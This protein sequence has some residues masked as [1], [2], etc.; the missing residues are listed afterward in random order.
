MVVMPEDAGV[1]EC[2]ESVN[3]GHHT[4][5]AHLRQHS[6][7]VLHAS[8]SVE[9]PSIY[10][11]ERGASSNGMQLSHCQPR[12]HLKSILD[13]KE[14]G[15]AGQAGGNVYDIPGPFSHATSSMGMQVKLITAH[16]STTASAF[17]ILANNRV[18]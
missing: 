11:L 6:K 13:A 10:G 7:P 17:V 16:T 3:C 15:H 2:V 14:H 18:V 12:Q 9:T 4:S 8:S 5:Q 1:H